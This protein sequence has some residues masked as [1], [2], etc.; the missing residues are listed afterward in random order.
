MMLVNVDTVGVHRIG[1]PAQRVLEQEL[2]RRHVAAAHARYK[3]VDRLLKDR[4]RDRLEKLAA[5]A[6]DLARK[7]IARPTAV[8]PDKPALGIAAGLGGGGRRRDGVWRPR[9]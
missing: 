7:R 5:Q 4:R 3:D 2:D 1:G 9:N 8:A 6:G